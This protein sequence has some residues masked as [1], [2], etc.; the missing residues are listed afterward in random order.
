[1]SYY[2]QIRLLYGV[3]IIVVSLQLSMVS[4]I[5]CHHCTCVTIEEYGCHCIA[6]TELIQLSSF[7]GGINL[8]L[9]ANLILG[10]QVVCIPLNL[11]LLELSYFITCCCSTAFAMLPKY[12]IAPKITI[13]VELLSVPIAQ[14]WRVRG[15]AQ[16]KR[17]ILTRALAGKILAA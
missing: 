15:A 8:T 12:S 3:Q 17:C 5:I 9:P 10:T 6:D 4:I 13:L 11:D 2:L 14:Y 1:M 7:P 16:I